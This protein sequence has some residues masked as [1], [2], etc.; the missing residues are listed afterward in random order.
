MGRSR[1]NVVLAGLV[2]AGLGG[3]GQAQTTPAQ[4]KQAQDDAFL[5]GAYLK[6]VPGLVAPKPTYEVRP[7]YTPDAMRAKIQ[8]VVTVQVV[9][10]PDGSVSRARIV[11]SLDKVTGLDDAAL[12]AAKKWKFTPG[13]YKD[14]PVPVAVHLDLEF[15]LH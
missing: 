10:E 6:E 3:I 9:V 15:K 2:V 1:W 8:G 7:K 4:T 5:K 11:E 14:K 12:E 13:T